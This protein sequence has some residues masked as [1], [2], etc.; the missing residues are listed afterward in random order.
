M[1]L[2]CETP[3]WHLHRH[4]SDAMHTLDYGTYRHDC[5]SALWYMTEGRVFW[6]PSTR[7]MRLKFAYEEYREWCKEN[8]VDSVTTLFTE[9][10]VKNKG[11]FAEMTNIKANESKYLHVWIFSL[12]SRHQNR[13]APLQFMW[14]HF[15]GAWRMEAAMA[16]CGRH[17]PAD[18]L[19]ELQA[20]CDQYLQTGNALAAWA[21]NSEPQRLL[22]KQI[23]KHH[24]VQ[25]MCF[26]FAPQ[27]NPR[28]VTCYMD[29]D[30]IGKIKKIVAK[31]HPKNMDYR[32]LQRFAVTVSLKWVRKANELGYAQDA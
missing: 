19:I 4:W 1:P 23:P 13:S 11:C 7:A 24:D 20:G 6:R 8:G 10:H 5:G 29:E 30:M 28:T 2:M 27:A 14:E 12:L 16:S 32:A 21:L 18:K 25:H 9:E 26:E 3:G 15:H 31:T 17:M 22:F